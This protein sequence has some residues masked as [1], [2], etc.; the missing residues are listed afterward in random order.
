MG[1][2]DPRTEL[3]LTG[4]GVI[5]V[6]ALIAFFAI[7]LTNPEEF[8]LQDRTIYIMLGII[9]ALLGLKT[10]SPHDTHPRRRS[11]GGKTSEPL[12]EDGDDGTT[13]PRPAVSGDDRHDGD[14]PRRDN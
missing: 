14:S 11:D 4:A 3:L 6:F 5:C 2:D 1:H 7:E 10:I 13:V 9:G 12:D 8:V